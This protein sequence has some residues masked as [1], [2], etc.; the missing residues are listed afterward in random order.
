MSFPESLV[1]EETRR[2]RRMQFLMDLT[3]T[4]IA[5]SEMSYEEAWN[6]IE[7][8]KAAALRLFPGEDLA[9][10]MIY[11]SRFRRLMEEKYQ[12]RDAETQRYG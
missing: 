6:L 1:E 2:Y 12:R 9:F 3:L 11:T 4:T 5:Q 7:S 10:E 8:A